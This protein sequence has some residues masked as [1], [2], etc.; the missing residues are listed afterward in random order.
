MTTT[1]NQMT[2]IDPANNEK[3][4]FFYEQDFDKQQMACELMDLREQVVKLQ[5]EVMLQAE[6]T[7]YWQEQ[8]LEQ[9]RTKQQIKQELQDR[10][11]Y[12][13]LAEEM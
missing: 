10:A 6:L 3:P 8:V 11:L 12:D 5:R 4:V 7:V 1:S 2:V 9:F 13:A